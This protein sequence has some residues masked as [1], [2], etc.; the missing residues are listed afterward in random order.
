M[1]KLLFFDI[2]GTIV[3][4]GI[5]SNERFIP[6]SLID[7]VEQLRA[8]GHLCFINTGRAYSELDSSIRALPFDGCVCGCGTYILYQGKELFSKHID[9]TLGNAIL[10]DLE[11]CRL[12]WLL[13]GCTYVYYS[14]SPYHTRIGT[15]HKEHKLLIP[16]SVRI[17]AP[18]QAKN[19][20]FDKFCICLGEEHDFDTFYEKYQN[21]LTFI[22]RGRGFYEIMPQE[23]SKASGIYFLE[24]FFHIP[25]E[26][27]IAIGDSTNDLPMLEYAGYSIA[28]GNSSREIL[29]VVDYVTDTV[30][31]NGIYQAMKH[32]KLI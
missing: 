25:R 8:K 3:T 12:E 4:E 9:Y 29:P 32:L 14:T 15:F 11:A 30:E 5:H 27:T 31:N 6:Q 18:E 1:K 22:D 20:D 2:D 26:D 28:M 21:I 10:K 17:I 13:E 16:D 24:T 19:L 7:A 23:C